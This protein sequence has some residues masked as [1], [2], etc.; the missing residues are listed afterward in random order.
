[1]IQPVSW[2]TSS[3]PYRRLRR[4]LEKECWARSTPGV[5][6]PPRPEIDSGGPHQRN[7]GH[8]RRSSSSS[9]T[10]ITRLNPHRLTRPSPFCSTICRHGCTWSLPAEP[11]RLYPYPV[12]ELVAKWSS[13]GLMTCALHSTEAGHLSGQG[14]GAEPIPRVYS[15]PGDS[16]RGL[17]C[18]PAIGRALDAGAKAKR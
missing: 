17:D 15:R 8:P 5:L 3:L 7:H 14:A 12:C 4:I 11:I 6:R 10:I 2:P 16:H 18:W 1:M 13:S 9:S